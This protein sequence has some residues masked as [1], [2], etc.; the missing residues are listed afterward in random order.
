MVNISR[1]NDSKYNVS[2]Y[3]FESIVLSSERL[4]NDID[5]K[6][7]VTD[8]EIYED[9][10]LPFVTG[11]IILVDK[12]K[13]MNDVDILGAEKIT[14][15]VSSTVE[16]S[17]SIEK[18][19]Y[20]SRILNTIRN[21]DHIEVVNLEIVEDI[22]YISN[23]KNVNRYYS[24]FGT[25]ILQKLAKSF[26]SKEINKVS[27]DSGS[28]N[29]IV[30]NLEPIEALM[31]IRN[32]MTTKDGYPFYLFST[33]A[34]KNLTCV[35]LGTILSFVPINKTPYRGY[36][37]A[38]SSFSPGVQ[39][40]VLNGYKFEESENMYNLI[41]KGLIGAEYRYFNTLNEN[42]NKIRFDISKDLFSPLKKS[43]LLGKQDQLSFSTD[44]KVDGQ[45]YNQISSRTITRIGG[46]GAYRNSPNEYQKSYD[47]NVLTGE[48]K[49]FIKAKAMSEFLQKMPTT[50]NIDGP[51]FIKGDSQY[52]IGNIISLQFLNSHINSNSAARRFDS[53][54]SGDYII[55]SARHIFKR[56]KY[57]I[58]VT[59]VKM[60]NLRR[61]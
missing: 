11:N 20:I 54:K 30:P 13:F 10:N 7:I 51:E 53:K 49:N 44:Y 14:I 1:N 4:A 55:K 5:I 48:Y 39:Q 25:T 28:M 60:G 12:S 2:G 3:Y 41:K 24:G 19:F 35:D 9:I 33:F 45:S 34:N 22:F 58:T 43:G 21:D 56:E 42:K 38:A 26:L 50:F 6:E 37:A 15:L 61:I 31:W 17:K 29:L 8:V 32:R 18:T 27:E 23:L 40:R 36:E 47:E 46:S 52:T 59:G 57:D 16:G